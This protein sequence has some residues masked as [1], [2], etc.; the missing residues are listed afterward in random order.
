MFPRREYFVEEVSS[1]THWICR[2]RVFLLGP[3]HHFYLTNCALSEF[4]YYSTPLGDLKLDQEVMAE[5]YET[6]HFGT[7]K[8]ETDE[9]EHSMELHLPYIYKILSKSFEQDSFPTLIPI[10]VGNTSPEVEVEFG[11][12]L[13]P[14]F[15]DPE[16]VFIISSDFAHWGLRFSYTNYLP[17]VSSEGSI[18]ALKAS[19]KKV[20][21]PKIYE[22]IDAIDKMTMGAIESGEH[23]TFLRSL[24]KTGNTVCGRHPIGIAMAAIE[25]LQQ[26]GKIVDNR[27]EFIQ[28]ARSS[29]C[30]KVSDS[31]VSYVSGYSVIEPKSK[32]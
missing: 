21:N 5:L 24:R 10:L 2:K 1:T 31:S 7:M 12:I 9:D 32:Q 30:L 16:N 26:D 23:K 15:E 22:S 28:Y 8:P 6:Q 17:D 19:E 3:S 4:A 14:Y 25:Q 20:D 29:N 27:F 11:K 13:A 18:R